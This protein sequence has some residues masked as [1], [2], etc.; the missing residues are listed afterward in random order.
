MYH[1]LLLFDGDTDQPIAAILRPGTCH[2]S[3][4]VLGILR[5]VVGAIR[6]RW[7]DVPI[8]LRADSGFGVPRLYQFCEHAHLTYTIASGRNDRLSALAVDRLAEAKEQSTTTGET[9][10]LFGE[11]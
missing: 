6:A 10:R 11:A 7:P 5:Q 3:R 4:G 8:E 2:A 1:P 9:A